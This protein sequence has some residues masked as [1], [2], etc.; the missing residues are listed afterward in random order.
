MVGNH[1]E[2][3]VEMDPELAIQGLVD[4]GRTVRKYLRMSGAVPVLQEPEEQG[5]HKVHVHVHMWGSALALIKG[6]I[7]A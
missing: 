1:K 5:L 4:E 3:L 6:M 7:R 2:L